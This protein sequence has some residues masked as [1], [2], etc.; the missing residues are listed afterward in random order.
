LLL[1]A[2]CQATWVDLGALGY[3]IPRGAEGFVVGN[4]TSDIN[5]AFIVLT[6]ERAAR[7]RSTR[8]SCLKVS[9][10]RWT[11]CQEQ[12]PSPL[13]SRPAQGITANTTV[14]CGSE[15]ERS[16]KTGSGIGWPPSREENPLVGRLANF[17]ILRY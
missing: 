3:G 15:M 6:P 1:K 11:R 2:R 17:K 4:I 9:R 14:A 13:K 5:R 7:P 16:P 8:H 10:D 12:R